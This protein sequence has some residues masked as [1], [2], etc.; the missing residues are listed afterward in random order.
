MNIQVV[1]VLIIEDH[2]IM[3]FGLVQLLDA[4]PGLNVC[5]AVSDGR[6][7]MDVMRQKPVNVVVL[8]LSLPDCHG[9]HL[10]RKIK[11]RYPEKA[12]LV[13]SMHDELRYGERVL[14]AGGAGY[15]TK[16]S[17]PA[18]V[19]DAV[20]KVARGG[21]YISEPLQDRLLAVGSRRDGYSLSP[22]D[23]L[24]DRELEIFRLLGSG[25]SSAE[26]ANR[27]QRSIKT[28]EAHRE[29][30]KK[31]LDL[32]HANELLR[33][34]VCWVEEEMNATYDVRSDPASLEID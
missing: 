33:Y 12:I 4:A 3:R 9:L 23:V 20:T 5:D 30:I 11:S 24:S 19:I 15:V 1:N 10:I 14:A 25:L 13:H 28:I 22:V 29:H 26:I 34:A 31:K 6:Q 7:A 17:S 2:D 21:M 18:R 32:R 16:N 27:L 8:D